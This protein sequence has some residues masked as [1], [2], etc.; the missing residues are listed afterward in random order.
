VGYWNIDESGKWLD[1][2]LRTGDLVRR[3]ADG[4]LYYVDRADDMIIS[5]GE[6]IFPQMVE[7]HLANHP[8]LSE[9]VVIGTPHPRWV[10]QVTAVVVARR[11]GLTVEDVLD[12]CQQNPDLTGM[13]KP[14]RVELVREIPRTGSG[15]VDRPELRR[16][17]E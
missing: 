5:G 12:W 1:G 10:Q 11:P 16:M 6:N 3:D 8:D 17:F 14:K 15:K 4:F 13:H 7:E 9:V 2:W